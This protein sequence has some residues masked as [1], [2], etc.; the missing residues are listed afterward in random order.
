MSGK[1]TNV[2]PQSGKPAKKL[3]S[4]NALAEK[5]GV[6][7]RTL[8]KKLASL[9]PD[10]EA[11]RKKLYDLEKVNEVLNQADSGQAIRDQKFVEEVRRLKRDNDEAEG[12]LIKRSD[13]AGAIAAMCAK[14]NKI[15]DQDLEGQFPTGVIGHDVVAVRA[16]C[17]LLADRMRA[18]FQLLKSLWPI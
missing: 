10:S 8:K 4:T 12:L 2:P 16:K 9:K 11:G 17:K 7:R 3:Y 18:E 6:D 15:L 1:K 14:V 13:V 5:T